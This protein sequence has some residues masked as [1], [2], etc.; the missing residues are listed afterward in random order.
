MIIQPPN[1][2]RL[3]IGFALPESDHSIHQQI[4][5]QLS[6]QSSKNITALSNLHITLC[7]LGNRQN[8]ETIEISQK[9]K[10]QSIKLNELNFNFNEFKVKFNAKKA[11]L[12][13]SY[14]PNSAVLNLHK[15][16]HQLFGIKPTHQYKPHVTYCRLRKD[17]H[18]INVHQFKKYKLS[19]FTPKKLILYESKL[20]S[21]GPKY[22][23]ISTI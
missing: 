7:F 5:N 4:I 21:V 8:E 14:T 6:Q 16:T 23:V 11:M 22:T 13:A 18:Q 15:T 3:F 19:D 10:N 12:W 20:T 1:T 9:F 2:Q 17:E